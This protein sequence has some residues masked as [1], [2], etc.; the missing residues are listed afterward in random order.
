MAHSGQS[1][2]ERRP[3]R[4]DAYVPNRLG[5]LV[6]AMSPEVAA[7]V[8][9]AERTIPALNAADISTRGR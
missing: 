1:R 6:L 9:D 8:S 3:C 5:D 7:D 4:H 2:A